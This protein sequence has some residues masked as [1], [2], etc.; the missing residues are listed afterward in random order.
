MVLI[1]S[2]DQEGRGVARV[3]GKVTF[4]DGA[5]PGEVVE[6]DVWKRKRSFDLAN[7]RT[8]V[9]GSSQ[10]VTPGCPHFDRCGGCSLQ[11][12]DGRAQMAMKQR[13]LEEDLRRIG[14][15]R[16][17]VV[18]APILGPSWGYRSRAR[19]SVRY[20]EKKGGALVGFHERKTHLVVDMDSCAVL[21]PAV[22]ALITPLRE[23]V[24]RL[25]LA[26]RLPQ[27]EIAVG[28]AHVVLSLRVLDEPDAHD[29]ARMREFEHAHAVEIQ[30]QTK[31]PDTLRPLCPDRARPLVYHLPEFGVALGFA[32]SEFTQ[33]NRSVNERLVARAVRML[34]PAPGQRMADLFCGLGNFTL[35]LARAGA[36]V[37]GM[38]GSKD[39]VERARSNAQS[40]GLGQRAT[41]EVADLFRDA[42]GAI[43]R[44][45]RLDALLLDP[46]RDGAQSV[47]TSLG[48]DA[49]RRLV[50]VSCNPATLARDAGILVG[51]KGYRLVEAGVVNM[52]PHTSH[53]E[54][55]A[56]FIRAGA[57]S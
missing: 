53:V 44:L 46:P 36:R 10:R 26:A 54:S 30:L 38:E 57:P 23:L 6:I 45:G 32:P 2:L 49:P 51:Q 7:V 47:V 13:V 5:L 55:I 48:E 56:C 50:Y 19:L 14:G 39:L 41:F 24:S 28:E 29:L 21:P 11:H 20:V 52:F 42:P 18:L 3:D 25:H 12:L 8:V 17:E 37:T 1:E 27:I 16:P 35:P 9:Q 4:V 33:I 22:S 34:Q 43:G 31:G 15:V 40:N